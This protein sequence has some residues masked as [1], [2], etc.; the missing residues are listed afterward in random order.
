MIRKIH[1]IILRIRIAFL[2]ATYHRNMRR[3]ELA[4]KNLDVIKFKTHAYRAEDAWRKLV[5]LS[6]KQKHNG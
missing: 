5:I 3:M 6:E 4:R 1:N 2:H